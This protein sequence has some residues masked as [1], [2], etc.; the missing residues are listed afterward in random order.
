[1]SARLE[2]LAMERQLLVAR[3]RLCRL[4]LRSR[5]QALRD[6]LSW[7]SAGFAV[8]AAPPARRLAFD[9][10]LAFVGGRRAAQAVAFAGRAVQLAR[11]LGAVA[12]LA[13]GRRQPAR[14]PN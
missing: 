14:E 8:A 13:G 3:S 9:L 5:T 7:R 12:N 1:M 11:L 4:R 10:A 6:S 2:V